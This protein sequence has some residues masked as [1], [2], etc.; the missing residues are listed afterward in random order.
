MSNNPETPETPEIPEYDDIN[1]VD[2]FK[3]N[4]T[5]LHNR[6][7]QRITHTLECLGPSEPHGSVKYLDYYWKG[8]VLGDYDEDGYVRN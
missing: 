8:E 1:I 6:W 5:Y 4:P 3:D 2:V 7:N